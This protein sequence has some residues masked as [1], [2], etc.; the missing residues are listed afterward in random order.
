MMR[1][2]ML[3]GSLFRAVATGLVML[4]LT[5]HFSPLT[6]QSITIYNDGRVLVRRSVTS[7]IPKGESSQKISLGQ[8][9]PSSIFSTDSLITIL[10][11]NYD[12]GTD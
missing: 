9:D 12:G 4:P 10:A 6:A 8:V 1:V 7:D 2:R 11:A 3:A 5:A